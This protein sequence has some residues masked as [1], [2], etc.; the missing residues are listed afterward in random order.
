MDRSFR[1]AL[2][3]F[4]LLLTG[5]LLALSWNAQAVERTNKRKAT[6][7]PSRTTSDF[8]SETV[9]PQD[10][11]TKTKGKKGK[12]STWPKGGITKV[13][14]TEG[15]DQL[16][17]FYMID[18]GQGDSMVAVCPG[19]DQ[20]PHLMLVDA[21]M[22][23]KDSAKSDLFAVLDHFEKIQAAGATDQPLK[24]DALVL[25]HP[26]KDHINMLDDVFT[27]IQPDVLTIYFGG[28]R[29]EY[30]QT[31][32]S[33]WLYIDKY[34]DAKP[35]TTVF[36]NA[37]PSKRPDDKATAFTATDAK[38]PAQSFAVGNCKAFVVA[39]NNDTTGDANDNSVM[40]KLEY[41]AGSQAIMLTGDGE[42]GAE[43]AA[44]KQFKDG[45]KFLQS[46]VLKV[47]H[48]G[49]N[50]SSDLEWV[51]AVSPRV[52]LI[53]SGIYE[54]MLPR[55]STIEVLRQASPAIN[56]GADEHNFACFNVRADMDKVFSSGG[57]A[58]SVIKSGI[59]RA[60]S[61]NNSGTAQP[62][63]AVD[64]TDQKARVAELLTKLPDS[65]TAPS[66]I[67]RQKSK[68]AIYGTLEDSKNSHTLHLVVAK[69]GKA[70][71]QTLK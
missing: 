2:G 17:D 3:L 18:V 50:T 7:T 28:K 59:K 1:K 30:K 49:S 15:G 9:D 10:K 66:L 11:K 62:T 20:K 32:A 53:S 27:A 6:S 71:V 44:L 51:A 65:K 55:C 36:G 14:Y 47:G 54:H 46:D 24:I 70:T 42:E 38:K 43:H 67:V 13:D 34:P 45:L 5:A 8:A 63:V 40:I 61:T 39:V 4:S 48:H 16:F 12:P 68:A 23:N 58:V 41:G 25:T 21:G 60:P 56:T 69:D 33:E 29:A 35:P 64:L 26:H 52:A 19:S 37:D 22:T 31:N 57:Q